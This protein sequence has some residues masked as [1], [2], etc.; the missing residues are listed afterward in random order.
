MLSFEFGQEFAGGPQPSFPGVFQA[1]SDA[2]PRVGVR[3]EIEQ[4]LVSSRILH[5][6]RS[7]PVHRQH[8][9][10]LALLKLFHERTRPAPEGRERLD[11][12]CDIEHLLQLL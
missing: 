12:L 10:A 3:S 4:T 2:L 1:L 8:H 5:N 6:R 9:G 7:L 11:V